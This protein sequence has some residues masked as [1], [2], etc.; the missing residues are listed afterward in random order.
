M[1]LSLFVYISFV[2]DAISSSD[3]LLV[4]PFAVN[5]YYNCFTIPSLSTSYSYVFYSSLL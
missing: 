4:S 2:N 1:S 5:F 3:Y